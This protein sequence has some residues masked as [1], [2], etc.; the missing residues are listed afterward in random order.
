MVHCYVADELV[1]I[2][3]M[4]RYPAAILREARPG[5]AAS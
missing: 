4:D 1:N 5:G 2:A 3:S